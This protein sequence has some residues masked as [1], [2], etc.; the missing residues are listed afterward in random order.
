[1]RARE[2]E[3]AREAAGIGAFAQLPGR[4]SCKCSDDDGGLLSKGPLGV[5]SSAVALFAVGLFAFVSALCD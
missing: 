4:S 5:A 3:L 1:M 2:L